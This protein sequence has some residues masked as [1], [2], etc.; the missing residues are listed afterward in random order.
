MMPP[1]LKEEIVAYPFPDDPFFFS[2]AEV[3]KHHT[4][5]NPNGNPKVP[6]IFYFQK[7]TNYIQKH[8]HVGQLHMNFLKDRC[9][10]S[11]SGSCSI[12]SKGWIGERFNGIPEPMPDYQ[13]LSK[14]HCKRVFDTSLYDNNNKTRETDDF[15]P[16]PNIA[17]AFNEGQLSVDNKEQM[18]TFCNKLIVE[19]HLVKDSL[20]HLINLRRTKG[21]RDNDRK[22]LKEAIKN[23]KYNDYNWND[24]VKSEE[25]LGKLRVFEL[26]RYLV[27]HGLS[28]NGKKGDKVSRIMT[29]WILAKDQFAQTRVAPNSEAKFETEYHDMEDEE[30]TISDDDDSCDESD[31]DD[32]VIAV[33]SGDDSETVNDSEDEEQNI[34]DLS[35]E[36]NNIVW[37]QACNLIENRTRSRRIVRSRRYNDTLTYL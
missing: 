23:K 20:E 1:C 13:R 28:K 5:S 30:K 24:L 32:E 16:R 26:D 3:Y 18:D 17:S 27:F 15:L 31:A 10:E 2:K 35:D 37:E 7:I 12:C 6:G 14:Y 22:R 25:V 9:D 34:N 4:A 8:Y 11:G 33:M 29:H 19:E 21:I 36:E